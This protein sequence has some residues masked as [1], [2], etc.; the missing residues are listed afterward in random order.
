MSMRLVF[1]SSRFLVYLIGFWVFCSCNQRLSPTVFEEL[2]LVS[3]ALEFPTSAEEIISCARKDT[4]ECRNYHRVV[5]AKASL[6][7]QGPAALDATVEVIR[8]DCMGSLPNRDTRSRAWNRCI[9]GL[10]AL[11]FFSSP[12]Q[13]EKVLEFFEK[14]PVLLCFA[15]AEQD[16]AWLHN[17]VHRERWRELFDTWRST[18]GTN[19]QLENPFVS[20]QGKVRH[21]IELL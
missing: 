13:D 11:Y 18:G 20:S 5:R 2:A 8:L 19:A 14:N 6:L 3:V 7:N 4:S 17:R 16:F 15:V 12:E 10:T 1:P 21:R 9:G